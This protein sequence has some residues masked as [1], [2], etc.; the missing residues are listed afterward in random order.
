MHPIVLNIP[1][2]TP[3]IIAISMREYHKEEIDIFR[4][5]VDAEKALKKQVGATIEKLYLN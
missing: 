4:K 5:T 2:N 3:H 1:D